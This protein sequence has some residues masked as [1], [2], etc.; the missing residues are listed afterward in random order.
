MK[1][2]AQDFKPDVR[3]QT[4][5]VLALQEASESKMVEL[6]EDSNLAAI[7]GKRVTVMPKDMRLVR[8][9]QGEMLGN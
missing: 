6:F 9:I 5:S 8:R 1:E 4:V 2:I 7:H 3:F